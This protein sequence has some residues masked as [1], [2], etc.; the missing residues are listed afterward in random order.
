MHLG[1][2]ILVSSSEPRFELR[3]DVAPVVLRFLLQSLLRLVP[4]GIIHFFFS[5]QATQVAF[6]NDITLLS[7]RD[8]PVHKMV[9]N[10]FCRGFSYFDRFL[11][12]TCYAFI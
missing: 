10:S 4:T 2:S 7:F 9:E 12:T 11:I 8:T 6:I 3:V 5:F 1:V